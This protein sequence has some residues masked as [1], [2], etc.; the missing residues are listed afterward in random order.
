[1]FCV[2][3]VLRCWHEALPQELPSSGPRS[4]GILSSLWRFVSI[5]TSVDDYSLAFCVTNRNI[6]LVLIMYVFDSFGCRNSIQWQN[7]KLA[8]LRNGVRCRTSAKVLVFWPQSKPAPPKWFRSF[9]ESWALARRVCCT[10]WMWV[11]KFTVRPLHPWAR[12]PKY[13]LNR[14][15]GGP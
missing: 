7:C 13:L 10:R 11:V 3:R 8:C 5:S 15:L 6:K 1:M 4:S 14:R 12:E 2:K 9:I